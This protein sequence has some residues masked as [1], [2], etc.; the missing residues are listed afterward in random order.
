MT[1]HELFLELGAPPG[2][3]QH[4]VSIQ[5][6]LIRIITSPN[7]ARMKNRTGLASVDEV[8]TTATGN[9]LNKR[10]NEQNNGCARA[11]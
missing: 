5:S 1:D 8:V 10:I 7:K 3:L 6:S 4:G 9:L 11:L 2:R